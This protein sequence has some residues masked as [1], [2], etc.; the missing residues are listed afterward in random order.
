[1][2]DPVLKVEK[3]GGKFV[4]QDEGNNIYGVYDNKKEAEEGTEFWREYYAAPLVFLGIE[5][6]ES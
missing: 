4:I 3:V 5:K 6:S 1:M 2:A